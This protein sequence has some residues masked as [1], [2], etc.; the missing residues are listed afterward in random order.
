MKQREHIAS[1]LC[2]FLFAVLLLMAGCDAAPA[3]THR[4]G[5]LQQAVPAGFFQEGSIAYYRCADC[6]QLRNEQK[7]EVHSIAIPKLSTELSICVNGSATPLTLVSRDDFQI[8]W[9][10]EALAVEAGDVV[11]IRDSANPDLVYPYLSEGMIDAENRVKHS[12]TEAMVSLVAT[13]DTMTLTILH[14]GI[15]VQINGEQ[16]PVD[17]AG[18]G[19]YAYGHVDLLAG[20]RIAII[21]T[22][23]QLTY[24]HDDL[25]EAYRWNIYDHHRGE[26]GEFVIDRDGRYALAFENEQVFIK[27]LFPPTDDAGYCVVLGG[28]EAE[29]LPME[30]VQLYGSD[31]LSGSTLS[32]P[33]TRHAYSTAVFLEAGTTF[34]IE[35]MPDRVRITGDHLTDVFGV[36]DCFRITEES[37]EIT[38]AGSYHIW[39]LPSTGSIAIEQLST[40]SLTDAARAFDKQIA[41]IPSYVELSYMDEIKQLYARYLRLPKSVRASLRIP[42]KLEAMYQRVLALEDTSSGIVYHTRTET[43]A[44]VYRSREE[45]RNAFFTD[46][47]Y[48]IAAYYGTV[49]LRAYSF[50][51]P[52][53]LWDLPGD[54]DGA[55]D[56]EF[57]EIGYAA[58]KHFLESRSNEILENQTEL[59]FVGF[60]YQNGLYREILPFLMR[61]FAYWRLDEGFA[62][63]TN[64]AADPF[65]E[66]WAPTVDIAKFFYF[67]ETTSY[68]KSARMIDCFVN[69]AG[70]V[71]GL[72]SGELLPDIKLRGYLFEGWYDNPE[73]TGDPVTELPITDQTVH[74]Y[75]KWRADTQQQ[76]QDSAALVDIYIYNLTTDQ[77]DRSKT[78]VGY[79]KDMYDALTENAKGLVTEYPTLQRYIDLFLK[80]TA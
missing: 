17:R 8:I 6:G 22:V 26:S 74:L 21:D 14:R 12:T 34:H 33:V 10:L 51:R 54:L 20:D 47:Y 67:N 56:P 13:P 52:E 27:K 66:G 39:Y 5:P 46:L 61:F 65:V 36:S 2:A 49:R 53:D 18:D 41:A 28:R 43:T 64:N 63:R 59:G 19:T 42:A 79:V 38:Q 58:G 60:C 77:A 75:A 76:D 40:G 72:D 25:A 31:I 68:V 55:D 7:A 78:K 44:Q 45:L 62:N 80:Q 57:N 48:Y 32:D 71:S 9:S 30:E 37:I 16:Y 15:V 11:T 73:F 3:E 69:T 70:V 1:I 29:Q 50:D 23:N 4:Y 35:S 24:G